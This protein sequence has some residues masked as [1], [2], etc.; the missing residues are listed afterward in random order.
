MRDKAL[1]ATTIPGQ[2]LVLCGVRSSIPLARHLAPTK[3]H[4]VDQLKARTKRGTEW[5]AYP[6]HF[7]CESRRRLAQAGSNRQFGGVAPA[8]DFCSGSIV[9]RTRRR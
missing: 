5:P 4:L 9:A 2:S 1:T 7:W 6:G 3:A 8:G